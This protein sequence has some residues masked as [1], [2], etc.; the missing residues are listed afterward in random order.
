MDGWGCGGED[1]GVYCTCIINGKH[2]FTTESSSCCFSKT[3]FLLT[4]HAPNALIT[5]IIPN[6]FFLQS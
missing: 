5:H 2:R 4:N 6:T 3:A 1:G